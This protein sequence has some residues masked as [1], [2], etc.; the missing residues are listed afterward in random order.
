MSY[1][2]PEPEAH[3]YN[4]PQAKTGNCA[5]FNALNRPDRPYDRGH[6]SWGAKSQIKEE[7]NVEV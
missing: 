6:C 2:D 4:C 3:C 7:K 5:E 1:I